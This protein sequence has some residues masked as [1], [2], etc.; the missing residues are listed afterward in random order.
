MRISWLV[1]TIFF[2]LVFLYG[3]F[4]V[5]SPLFS[6]PRQQDLSN[7]WD[8]NYLVEMG[9]Y[10][11]D[12]GDYESAKKFYTRALEINPTNARALIGVANCEFFSVF[13][14]TNIIGFYQEISSNYS[15]YTNTYDFIQIYLTNEKF[16][17]VSHR[18]S[19]NLYI[20]I[21]GLSDDKSLTNDDNLHL[22]FAVFNKINSFYDV[23]DFNRNGK[24]DPDDLT[25]E[26][27]KN[28]DSGVGVDLLNALLFN[29]EKVV[30]LMDSYF[31]ESKKCMNSLIFITNK[32][33]SKSSSVEVQIL[34]AFVELDIQMTNAYTNFMKSYTF[35]SS[36]YKR[37]VVLLTNNGIP[38]E[39]ATN[40]TRLTNSLNIQ[41]YSTF[42]DKEITNILYVDL[43]NGWNILTNYIDLNKLTN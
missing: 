36:M 13:S 19:R 27:I 26:F 8:V 3:C 18:I 23:V 12:V 29:G 22:S 41:D 21:S 16:F 15:Q 42:D 24:V 40:I 39:Y 4:N 5:F 32:F 14:R 17:R 33:S 34:K 37:I 11:A 2:L 38:L 30:K 28:I 7:I 43:T 25:Y 35:Y 6:D 31:F 9:D 10:Y 1:L 20:V